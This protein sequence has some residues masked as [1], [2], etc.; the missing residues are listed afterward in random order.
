MLLVLR[1]QTSEAVRRIL[2]RVKSFIFLIFLFNLTNKENLWSHW[3]SD[4][5]NHLSVLYTVEILGS[6]PAQ[7]HHWGVEG[8]ERHRGTAA[9]SGRRRR[10][11]ALHHLPSLQH[12][13]QKTGP[14]V[15][16]TGGKCEF[17]L[18]FTFTV[19]TLNSMCSS[20][21]PLCS[22]TYSTFHKPVV[23]VAPS[24]HSKN[25]PGLNPGLEPFCG[26][27]ACSPHVCVGYLRVF[28]LP[29]TIL[30]DMP[31]KCSYTNVGLSASN[32]IDSV[33]EYTSCLSTA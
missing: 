26:A 16:Q 24:S 33:S 25:V 32:E 18:Q 12:E 27:A 7:H 22:F 15:L 21:V 5:R 2:L 9:R 30:W 4:I 29:P 23:P 17:N 14:T 31:D 8:A 11:A 3:V 1:S 28:R 19:D 20:V 10:Q 6:V 13:P